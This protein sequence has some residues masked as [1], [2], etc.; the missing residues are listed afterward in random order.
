MVQ[1]FVPN[2][3]FIENYSS[4]LHTVLKSISHIE[5]VQKNIPNG[6]SGLALELFLLISTSTLKQQPLSL[7]TIFNSLSYSEAGIRK[8]L[9]N[10]FDGDWISTKESKNDKRVRYIIAKEK[11]L[12]TLVEYSEIINS[13]YYESFTPPTKFT[14]ISLEIRKF[15]N[16]KID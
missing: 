5:W 9:R 15:E 11:M 7:K 3:S 14:D 6:H 1:F 12:F 2:R 10:L 8:Q 16:A 4:V 13:T